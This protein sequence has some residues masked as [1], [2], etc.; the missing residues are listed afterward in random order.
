MIIDFI[1]T[2]KLDDDAKHAKQI[3]FSSR[4]FKR[5]TDV[6]FNIIC[7]GDSG[8]NVSVSIVSN[9]FEGHEHHSK[10]LM[11][12]QPCTGVGLKRTYSAADPGYAFGTEA[13]TTFY[14]KVTDFVTP[15]KVQI[16]FAQ[17][18]PINWVLFFVIFAAYVSC[19][20]ARLM[21]II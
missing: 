14:V 12:K 6:Q 8:A 18:P 16:S 19:P 3:F 11:L 1:F 5:D 15:I 17:S 9:S 7:E 2:F 4:P 13:N 20:M 21:R 10:Q